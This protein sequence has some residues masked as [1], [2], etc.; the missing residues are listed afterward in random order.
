[1]RILLIDPPYTIFAGSDSRY[2]PVQLDYYGSAFR[3]RHD[4]GDYNFSAEYE[5]LGD[6]LKEINSNNHSI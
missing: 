4:T 6:Y 1:M 3:E 2:F 5:R